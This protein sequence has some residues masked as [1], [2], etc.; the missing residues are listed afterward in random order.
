MVAW[1][2]ESGSLQNS[3]TI[4]LDGIHPT[5]LGFN[6]LQTK[7]PYPESSSS[8]YYKTNETIG[9]TLTASKAIEASGAPRI[10]FNIGSNGPYYAVWQ[11]RSGLGETQMYFGVLVN[12]AN[13]PVDGEIGNLSINTANGNI[14]D[15]VGNTLIISS[16]SLPAS[17]RLFVDKTAPPAPAFTLGLTSG[18]V[19]NV[20]VNPDTV[21]PINQNPTLAIPDPTT[22]AEP[23]GVTKWYST[24]GGLTWTE[25]TAQLTPITANGTY[26]MATR[27]IDRAGNIGAQSRQ[28]IQV[29]AQFPKLVSVNAEQP[30]GT[31][32]R[33]QSL[34]FILGFDDAVTVPAGGTAT[35]TLR[36]R[37]EPNA[38]YRNVTRNATVNT[39]LS[40]TVIVDWQ[41]NGDWEMP[42][43]LYI[44]EVNFTGMR[45][46]FNNAGVQS[47]AATNTANIVMPNTGGI[48][49]T[50]NCANLGTG[51]IVDTVAPSVTTYSPANAAGRT[52]D[53]RTSVSAD[54]KT[55]TLTF[56]ERV[57][58]G[59]GTITIRPYGTYLIPPVFEN[60]GY[61]NTDGTWVAGF[62]EIYN[63]NALTA[64]DRTALTRGTSMSALE[65]D[66]R[67]GQSVG[68]YVK[69][70]QGLKAGAGYSGNYNNTTP[71]PN[72][73]NPLT[74]FM[75]PD[76]ATKWVLDYRYSIDNNNNTNY[77]NTTNQS[78]TAD[79]TVVPAI[80]AVLTKVKWRWQE[81]DVVSSTSGNGDTV[82]IINLAEP[83]HKGL[84]WGLHYPQGAFTDMAG[85]PAPALGYEANGTMSTN[86][87]HWFWSSGVQTPVVRVNRK[88]FDA[89]TAD[90]ATPTA[91]NNTLID[92][93][94][95]PASVPGPG[96]WGIVDFNTVHYRIETETPGQRVRISYGTI[97][98]KNVMHPT[99]TTV[100]IGSVI[101]AGG[102]SNVG[103]GVTVDYAGTATGTTGTRSWNTT[104]NNTNGEW[105]R[106]NLIRRTNGGTPNSYQVVE[107]PGFPT[108]TR[109]FEGTYRGYRSHNKDAT[110]TDINN[111]TL[112]TLTGGTSNTG[113][114]NG[115]NNFTYT[116]LEA[117]KNYVVAMAQIDHQSA[118][119][120][121][122]TPTY[123]SIRGYE[124]VFRS[125]VA[126]MQGQNGS[127]VV[128]GS[129]IKNGMPSIA[130]F[131]V[132]DAA[133]AGDSRFVKYFFRDTTQN[134]QFYWVS[135]EIVSQ[136]YFIKF[137]QGTHQNVG[138][139]NNYL[140]AGYGDLSF[141][142]QITSYN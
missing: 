107:A 45:D 98:G 101:A 55:I 84:Q 106:P 12:T 63:N 125:V 105:V 89:R 64:A 91:N 69:M 114:S 112:G 13:T 123:A 73:P 19:P 32:V 1:T 62:Y 56:R 132:Q 116:A 96:G 77:V 68:P 130:G 97:E 48:T 26:D 4:R 76:T 102:A 74:G 16:L 137:G 133:E 11:P 141:G 15:G 37:T 23:Y 126:L 57:M 30:N 9:F 83:L 41:L 100:P 81:L 103:W 49:G 59:N 38:T 66:T 6:I 118:G 75:I 47:T 46:S 54:N 67:T 44:S 7:D 90:W 24:D 87:S 142:Y 33:G 50:Y 14:V 122:T 18:N 134:Q 82:I 80:R 99:S 39:T 5:I 92:R 119:T 79:A 115:T 128:E 53:V 28:K 108:V 65:L 138:E 93:Y 40:S 52:G 35:I 17:T 111:V 60:E 139:V 51:L 58:A 113:V 42:N 43:G 25:Y 71:G 131:P 117:S 29:N 78:V 88:S 70:T 135:T 31:Y 3:K 129:N 136:W 2:T 21:I 10:Q 27:Y 109:N 127:I 121:Y 95:A 104:T 8:Y 36:D 140:T 61:T 86:S 20:G 94:N 85:N 124:G 110:M 120:G 34:R 22:A 72:G